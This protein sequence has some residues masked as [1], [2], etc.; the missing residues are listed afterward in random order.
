MSR[1]TPDTKDWTWVLER[2]CDECGAD[3]SR[4]RVP[5]LPATLRHASLGWGALLF[6]PDASRKVVPGRWSVLEY[7]CHVRDVHR[8][9]NAR[10]RLMLGGQDP[11]FES[12]DQDAAA[13]Q[14]RYAEQDPAVVDAELVEA[15]AE[16]AAVYAA[17]T[18]EQWLSPG[19]RSNGSR[20]TV[21]SLAR[22]HL[23]DVL[24]HLHDVGMPVPE[25]PVGPRTPRGE[26]PEP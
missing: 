2:P 6:S 19:R 20:F 26:W 10:V 13:V 4:W 7:A 12:W 21:L 5:D 17:T 22:Y 1:M 9:M 8:V 23:H 11:V 24:H 3:V 18:P 15:A 16:V 14:D 25:G